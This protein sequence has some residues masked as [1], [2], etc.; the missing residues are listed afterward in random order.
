MRHR[1]RIAHG[2]FDA[3]APAC[4][5]LIAALDRSSV[6]LH[7]D[8]EREGEPAIRRLRVEGIARAHPLSELGPDDRPGSITGIGKAS[9]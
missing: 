7:L 9:P 6:A 1:R 4:A 5:Q 2:D 3:L 8:C